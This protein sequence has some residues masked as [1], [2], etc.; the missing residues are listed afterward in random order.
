MKSK[1][2][3]VSVRASRRFFMPTILATALA[4]A[5]SVKPSQGQALFW[6]NTG[7]TANAWNSLANWST[8]VAGGTNPA[9]TPGTGNVATFSATPI[10]GTAQTVSLNNDQSIQGLDFTSAVTT[11]TTLQA[12]GTNRIL[13]LGT[14][15]ITKAG[16]GAVTIGSATAGQQVAIALNAAQTWTNSNNTGAMTITNGV[17]SNASGARELT[18]GGT[19]T[20]ANTVSGII[21]NGSGTVS[22]AKSG[23][24]NWT[25]SGANTYTGGTT[26]SGGT[27]AIS[28]AASMGTAAVTV[29]G[30]STLRSTAAIT[31]ANSIAVNAGLTLSTPTTGN[32]TSTYSGLL[33]GASAITLANNSLGGANMATFAFTN[34]SNTFTGNVILPS[35][36]GSSEAFS[37]ASIGDGGN[38]TYSRPSWREMVIYTGACLLYTSDA[39][40]E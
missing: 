2:S 3:L 17:S 13:T 33:S 18:L 11:A 9:A 36:T 19:S 10:V 8:V 5:L 7:G 4:L 32:S 20:A 26:I 27:L 22:V 23:A 28:N 30:A 6:D 39:A 16:T 37:F 35:T 12:G 1:Y 24:G 38:F 34:T 21:A 15:G 14:S 31:Y 29:S 40:D 25:L